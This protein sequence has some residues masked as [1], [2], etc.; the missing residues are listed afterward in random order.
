MLRRLGNKKKI[1]KDIVKHFPADITVFIDLCFGTGAI[2]YEMLKK[3]PNIY[4]IANDIDN[5][6]ANLWYIMQNKNDFNKLFEAVE[7]C[8]YH[9]DIYRY[10][11]TLEP[12]NKIDKA[13]R[14]LYLSNFSVN[15]L[16]TVLRICAY[17]NNKRNLLNDMKDFFKLVKYINFDNLDLFK[18]NLPVSFRKNRPNE[19]KGQFAYLDA[20]YIGTTDNYKNSFTENDTRKAIQKLIDS[21]LRFAVSEFKT[22]I[23][24]QIAKDYNLNLIEIVERRTSTKKRNIEILMTNYQCQNNNVGLFH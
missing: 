6:I 22:K 16:P 13:L 23:T 19:L 14:F 17:H 9:T 1:A 15:G 20:P 7:L 24:E 3:H 2:T 12:K 5:D 18:F 4:F 8:P 10:F 11:K 21:G